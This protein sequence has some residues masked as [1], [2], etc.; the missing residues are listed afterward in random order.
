M[1]N[2]LFLFETEIYLFKMKLNT[3]INA[4]TELYILLTKNGRFIYRTKTHIYDC[5]HII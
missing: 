1:E 5:K 3:V 2:Q 4:V